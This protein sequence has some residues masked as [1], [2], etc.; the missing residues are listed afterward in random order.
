MRSRTRRAAPMLWPPWESKSPGASC[1]KWRRLSMADQ[2]VVILRGVVQHY[3][4]GGH[5]FIPDLLGIEN[6]TRKPYAELWMGAHSK[7]PSIVELESGDVPLD[8]FIAQAPEAILGQAA[9]A[10]FDG[11]LPYLFKI[12]DVHKM[13][14]IQAHPTL[15]QAKEGFARE[16]AEGLPIDAGNRNYKDATHKPEIGVALTDFWMLH[17]FR[18]LEQIAETLDRTAELGPLMPA[19]IERLKPA[20]NDNKSTS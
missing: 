12:L 4:W 8:E 11:R 7:A 14:S 6:A 10:R 19:F 15:A 3:D 20:H 2:D 13:L 16:N 1:A 9:S 18:P 17:G 5:N